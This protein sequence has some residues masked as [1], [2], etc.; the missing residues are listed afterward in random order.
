MPYWAV[1]TMRYRRA[2]VDSGGARLATAITAPA[3]GSQPDMPGP[4]RLPVRP[5]GTPAVIAH[6]PW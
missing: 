5:A 4:R 3:A 1:S 2:S 6:S